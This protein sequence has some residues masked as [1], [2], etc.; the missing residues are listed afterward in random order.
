MQTAAAALDAY[1]ATGDRDWLDWA[2]RLMD[3]VWQ[4]YWD[5]AAEDCSTPPG[6]APRRRDCFL[7]EPSRYRTRPRRPP[8]EWRASSA[9]GCTS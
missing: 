3:R 4:D 7:P 5:G 6:A 9:R 2:V 1:E 8:M